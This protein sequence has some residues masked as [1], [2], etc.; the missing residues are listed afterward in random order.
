MVLRVCLMCSFFHCWC[1]VL[2]FPQVCSF[3]SH[4]D[5]FY[6]HQT[7]EE[8]LTVEK[9]VHVIANATHP[10]TDAVITASYLSFL[11]RWRTS[12]CRSCCRCSNTQ[13]R[14]CTRS[15]SFTRRS[16]RAATLTPASRPCLWTKPTCKCLLMLLWAFSGNNEVV[17]DLVQEELWDS[18][19]ICLTVSSFCVQQHEPAPQCYDHWPDSADSPLSR[20]GFGSAVLWLFHLQDVMVSSNKNKSP[21][22][23]SLEQFLPSFLIGR[24]TWRPSSGLFM[25]AFSYK[26]VG[27]SQIIW[28]L[29]IFC[30]SCPQSLSFVINYRSLFRSGSAAHNKPQL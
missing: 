5:Y 29:L 18:R 6:W 22:H 3:F 21:P 8:H 9:W 28:Y 11:L 1:T 16:W 13:C 25:C 15:L 23:V 7:Q 12:A 2:N 26:H 10:F 24:C 30:I 27:L 17:W 4:Q 20:S 19:E 14:S